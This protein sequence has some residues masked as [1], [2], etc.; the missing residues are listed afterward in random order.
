[1]T[2]F[3]VFIWYFIAACG[4]IGLGAF[5]G[6]ETGIYTLNRVRLHVL[7]HDPRSNAAIMQRLI[8][9]PNRL[10]GTLLVGNNIA[11]YAASLAI[12]ALLQD[13]GFINWQQIAISATV[14]T[15]LLFVFGEVLPKDLFRNHADGLT[16][17]LARPIAVLSRLLTWCGV[18]PM[19]GWVSAT[20]RR[21][22]GAGEIQ[23]AMLHPR[24]IMSHLLREGAGHGV[25]S[26]SQSDIIERA[27]RV[28]RQTVQEVMVP[29]R[30]AVVART[31]QPLEALWALAGRVTFSRVPLVDAAGQ[32]VGVLELFDILRRDPATLGSVEQSAH[33]MIELPPTTR[34]PEALRRLQ[35]YRQSMALIRTPGGEPMG[36]VT[37]KNLVEPI[38]GQL[39]DW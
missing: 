25:I 33:P 34:L 20:L 39:G 35:A 16:I 13:A 10:L 26:S 28:N 11:N 4:L 29:W 23:S 30:Q 22:L 6:I 12:G 31:S 27:L 1:M 2:G 3:E 7:A 5:S 32:P 24:R 37:I 14:L 9:R 38:V 19:I 8:A 36:L 15:P 17:P 21:L 18:L